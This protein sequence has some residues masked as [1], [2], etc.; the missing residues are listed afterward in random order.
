MHTL[1]TFFNTQAESTDWVSNITKS[2][3]FAQAKQRIAQELKGFTV[4]PSF[5]ELMIL[6]LTE[7]LDIDI[8]DI[9]V[10]GWRKQREIVQYR[11]K[12]NPPGGAHNVPLLEHTLV[13]KHSPTLQPV[14]NSVRL[15]KLKFDILLKLKMNS[16]VLIIRD[17]K[18]MAV[19]TGNCV[20]NGSIAYA[21]FTLLEKKTAPVNLP[22]S[23]VFKEGIPI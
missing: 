3:E 8:G 5:Y 14:V 18:I 7:A 11:G 23:I 6:K 12:E 17:G 19:Q 10:W 21:G 4:P 13:S 15:A 1:N 2:K 22:G 20:G 16:A 9:L